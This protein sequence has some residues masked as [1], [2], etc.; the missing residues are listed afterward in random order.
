MNKIFLKEVLDVLVSVQKEL[1]KHAESN[2]DL[3]LNRIIDELK[4]E[5][6]KGNTINAADVLVLVG[7]ALDRLPSVVRLIELLSKLT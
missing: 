1:S 6:D 2:V 5:I 7:K 4:K 3:E